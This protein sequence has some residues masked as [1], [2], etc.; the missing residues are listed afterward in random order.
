[1]TPSRPLLHSSVIGPGAAAGSESAPS[2]ATA[3]GTHAVLMLH[4]IYGRGRNWQAIAQRLVATRPDWH[5]LLVDLRQHGNSPAFDP[6][7]T[8]ERTAD[9][10]RAFAEQAGEQGTDV[11]AVLGHSFGGKVA[12]ALARPLAA[13]LRQVWVI[14]STP[15]AKAPAGSAWDMLLHVRSLPN[16]FHARADLVAGLEHFGWPEGVAQWMATNLRYADGQYEWAL[17]FD[18]MTAMLESFFQTDLWDVVE[19]PPANVQIHFV[20]ATKSSTL[21]EQACERIERAGAASG[22]VFLHRLE[23]GHWLNADNPQGIVDLL[24]KYLA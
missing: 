2:V 23:G 3:A 19:Q 22:R 20:K 6:P 7:H 17:D 14:D 18:A 16:T 21:S 12:L 9:D 1:M 10:V 5:A 13:T 8:V 4:G 24:A 11:R 15:E